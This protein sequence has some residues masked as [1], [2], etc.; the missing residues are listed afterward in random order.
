MNARE[1]GLGPAPGDG[2]DGL[3]PG[4]CVTINAPR[5]AANASIK[6]KPRRKRNGGRHAGARAAFLAAFVLRSFYDLA[7]RRS[8]PGPVRWP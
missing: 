3:T 2:I 4:T 1:T 7:I 5:A 6:C 8:K